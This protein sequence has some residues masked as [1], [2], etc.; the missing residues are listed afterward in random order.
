MADECASSPCLNNGECIKTGRDY[1]C[2]CNLNFTGSRCETD[3][4]Y[5]KE[6]SH[7]KITNNNYCASLPCLNGATCSNKKS[8]SYECRCAPNYKG[9]NCELLIELKHDFC[10]SNPCLNNGICSESETTNYTCEC[11]PG[12]TGSRCQQSKK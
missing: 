5:K 2:K 1:T 9:I 6:N 4:K 12:Y 11:K 3:L 8:D 7:I 10:S